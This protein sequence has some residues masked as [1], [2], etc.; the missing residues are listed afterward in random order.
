MRLTL[1][2]LLALTLTPIASFA[3]GDKTVVEAYQ[4]TI[5]KLEV[6]YE[7]LKRK[8]AELKNDANRINTLIGKYEVALETTTKLI[9]DAYHQKLGAEAQ[10]AEQAR[11]SAEDDAK[12][13]RAILDEL[14]T[15]AEKVAKLTNAISVKNGNVGIGTTNPGAKLEVNG[16]IRLAHAEGPQKKGIYSKTFMVNGDANTYY[17][18]VISTKS[19]GRVLNMQIWR[20]YAWTAPHTWNTVTHKGSLVLELEMF[21]SKWSGNGNMYRI[22]NFY[23]GY[24]QVI[25]KITRPGPSGFWTVLWLR[26]GGAKYAIEGDFEGVQNPNVYYESTKIADYDNNA[27]D[28]TVAP[29]TTVEQTFVNYSQNFAGK[30]GIG[31]NSPQYKLDVKGQ[32]RADNVTVKSDQR[33]KQNIHSLKNALTKLQGLRGVSFKWKNNTQNADPQIGLIAQ[34]VEK[35]LPELV[36]TDSE[37]YKSIAYGKL[38]AVLVEAL[39]EQQLQIERLENLIQN[40]NQK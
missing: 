16:N 36:S 12:A 22:K 4:E 30:V 6:E 24:S 19:Y 37:G 7:K 20:F 34:E 18:V 35:V 31:T 40:N 28:E 13:T 5:Q 8:V 14:G 9:K 27:Y 38:T 10:L 23:Q 26:G 39:K 25:S 21:G 32:V 29:T 15:S 11:Q 33:H 1:V 2:V 3:Y 17:P